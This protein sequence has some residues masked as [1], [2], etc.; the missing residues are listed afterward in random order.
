M[1]FRQLYLNTRDMILIFLDKSYENRMLIYI[2]IRRIHNIVD[3]VKTYHLR[4]IFSQ[5]GH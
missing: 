1:C 2:T 5:S 3:N 4:Y